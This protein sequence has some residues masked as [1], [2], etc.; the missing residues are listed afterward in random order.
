MRDKSLPLP[1]TQLHSGNLPFKTHTHTHWTR[2]RS[3][4]L[5]ENF[6]RCCAARGAPVS[7]GGGPADVASA[8]L[9]S[10]GAAR[11]WLAAFYPFS[12]C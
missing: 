5:L 8:L 2:T 11:V 9:L 3:R 10:V 6:G 7:A 1:S 12:P 4:A